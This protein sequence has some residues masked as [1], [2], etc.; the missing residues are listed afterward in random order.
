MTFLT[1]EV[2]VLTLTFTIKPQHISVLLGTYYP[3][4]EDMSFLEQM[5]TDKGWFREETDRILMCQCWPCRPRTKTLYHQLSFWQIT[6][7]TELSENANDIQ[8]IF[9]SDNI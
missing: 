6:T 4:D 1:I 2:F 9:N 8:S 5:A 3:N 7:N